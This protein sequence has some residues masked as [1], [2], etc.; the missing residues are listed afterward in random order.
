MHLFKVPISNC[1]LPVLYCVVPFVDVVIDLLHTGAQEI[2]L[3]QLNV[4][5]F[6]ALKSVE[7]FAPDMTLV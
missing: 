7:P 1:V 3:N 4:E 2:F 6:T 5:A